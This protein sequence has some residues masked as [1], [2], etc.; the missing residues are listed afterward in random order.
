[1]GVLSHFQLSIDSLLLRCSI[2]TCTP[3]KL[4]RETQLANIS[5]LCYSLTSQTSPLIA[6][7]YHVCD[8]EAN[9][10][11]VWLVRLAFMYHVCDTETNLCC[12]WLVRLALGYYILMK[13]VL[14]ASLQ[15]QIECNLNTMIHTDPLAFAWNDKY[16]CTLTWKPIASVSWST[17]T[18]TVEEK[19][20]DTRGKLAERLR[21]VIS[22]TSPLGSRNTREMAGS[23]CSQ[24]S[25][26]TSVR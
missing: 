18:I 19:P 15:F 6:F 24:G 20:A 16:N 23:G 12:V 14:L 11:C 10:C 22:A 17:V 7:M 25:K 4:S 8:T 1:M 26:V 13:R 9:L 2:A 3:G 5:K 21:V